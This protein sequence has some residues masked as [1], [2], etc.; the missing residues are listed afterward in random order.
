MTFPPV[1]DSCAAHSRQDAWQMPCDVLVLGSGLAGLR[2]AWAAAQTD[3]RARVVLATAAHGPS[4]SSF[5]NRNARLGFL[6]PGTDDER[7]AL[8]A[9]AL[10]IAAPGWADPALVHI[11]MDEAASRLAELKDMGSP[12]QRDRAGEMVRQPSCFAHDIRCA[13]LLT[14]LGVLYRLLMDQV[15][16]LG[17]QVLPGHIA[18][19]ILVADEAG[20]C[21]ALLIPADG[22]QPMAVRARAVVA[23]LGGPAPL[24]AA[25]IVGTG[26]AAPFNTIQG[27]GDTPPQPAEADTWPGPPGAGWSHLLLLRAGADLSNLGYMQFFWCREDTRDFIRIAQLAT[28]GAG[29]VAPNGEIVPPP[30]AIAAHARQRATHCPASWGM[31]D[32]ALDRFAASHAD[33]EGVVTMRL[34]VDKAPRRSKAVSSLP[35]A[36]GDACQASHTPRTNAPRSTLATVRA[37]PMA[38]CCNGGA[39]ID[40][41][42]ATTVPGLFA[43]GECATGMHGANRLGGAM[44]SATQVFGAR[45]GR[46]A[47]QHATGREQIS[48]ALFDELM[49]QRHNANAEAIAAPPYPLPKTLG[50]LA[51]S[52]NTQ[53]I[54]LIM[55]TIERQQQQQSD[56]DICIQLDAALTAVRFLHKII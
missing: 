28:T 30:S 44:V 22:G 23:A 40:A 33:A 32:A 39:R 6:A 11:L 35:P 54:K 13:R 9:R 19:E 29:M 45:A 8:A 51:L 41:H 31:P 7:E 46:A 55:D 12:V 26:R 1:H 27:N 5:T 47:M 48:V 17:V 3:P 34:P 36:S 4:G 18:M 38:H 15:R 16:N 50:T 56:S 52:A 53:H 24:F 42:G 10:R 25:N 49:K 14:D 20:A 43:V 37:L 2:A 21:G